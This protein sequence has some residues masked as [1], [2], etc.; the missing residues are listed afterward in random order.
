MA[1]YNFSVSPWDFLGPNWQ[2]MPA[3]MRNNNPGNIKYVGQSDALGPSSNTDQGDPQ[4]VF[5]SPQAGISAM[6]RLLAKKYAGGKVTANDIIAGNGGW[7]PGN[8]QAAANVAKYA[9]IG[10]NDDIRFSDP[11]AANKFM[12]GLMMQEHG[13][14]SKAY[15]GL[16]GGSV[17]APSP[18]AGMAD[19]PKGQ[20]SYPQ[21]VLG[22]PPTAGA[23]KPSILGDPSIPQDVA[24]Y[25]A[26][27]SLSLGDRLQSAFKGLAK[28]PDAPAIRFGPMGDARQSGSDLLKA[29]NAP[30]LSDLL[31]QKRLVG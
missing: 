15:V 11:A 4:A 10:P 12:A 27:N 6:Q 1:N 19:G 24:A 20:E 16:L 21:P 29:L 23:S 18:Y 30:N 7:T 28:T 17:P 5:A 14:A 13:P 31:A 9:G 2:R 8:F 26:D 22:P 3:G 25:A